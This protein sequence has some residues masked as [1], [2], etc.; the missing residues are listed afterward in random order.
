[1]SQCI[2]CPVRK[3]SVS[4]RAVLRQS[5]AE[6]GWDVVRLDGDERR[7]FRSPLFAFPAGF[8]IE[9]SSRA[10]R[11]EVIASVKF[12][13]PFSAGMRA[14]PVP[15]PGRPG[16]APA[17]AARTGVELWTVDVAGEDR[18]LYVGQTRQGFAQRM[19]QHVNGMF[20]FQ[21][22]LFDPKALVSRV[23]SL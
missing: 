8:G 10:T 14:A 9:E 5:A 21:Y 17:V 13:G 16:D 23:V 6:L 1:M 19:R 15:L 3:P 4:V 22:T 12:E 20:S 2:G 7:R 11:P 18:V